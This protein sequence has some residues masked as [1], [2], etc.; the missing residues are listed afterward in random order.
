M[1][2]DSLVMVLEILNVR[3][4][5]ITKL[6]LEFIM[7]KESGTMS[8]EYN[9]ILMFVLTIFL[10]TGMIIYIFYP[11]NDEIVLFTLQMFYAEGEGLNG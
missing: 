6:S 4:C 10:I 7:Q 11:S 1:S 9:K 5:L 3:G 2:L 8:K